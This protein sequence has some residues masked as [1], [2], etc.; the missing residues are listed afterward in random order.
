M[1]PRTDLRTVEIQ[2]DDGSWLPG[3]FARLEEGDVIR[4]REPDGR[5]VKTSD[6]VWELIVTRRPQLGFEP[7]TSQSREARAAIDL[8]RSLH[9]PLDSDAPQRSDRCDE[10][11][12][13]IGELEKALREVLPAVR[14]YLMTGDAKAKSIKRKTWEAPLKRATAALTI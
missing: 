14:A 7:A 3:D 13:R 6:G 11:S 4:M 8:R 9:G 10:A 5:P 1:T 12:P 2:A